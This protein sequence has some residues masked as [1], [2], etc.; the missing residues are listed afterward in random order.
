MLLL[1]NPLTYETADVIST[2][3]YRKGILEA[4]YSFTA[5]VGLF[6]SVISFILIVSAN[7]ISKRV[8]ENKLW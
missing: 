4:S 8:S 5:A 2:Y 6:N 7:A 1:Y 3:V